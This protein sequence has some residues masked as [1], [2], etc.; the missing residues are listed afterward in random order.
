MRFVIEYWRN[1][2]RGE[3]LGLSTSQFIS[4]I[5]VTL[6]T[7]TYAIFWMRWRRSLAMDE[8]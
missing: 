5:I 3:L 7:I 6:A 4:L 2:W 1:D 8:S